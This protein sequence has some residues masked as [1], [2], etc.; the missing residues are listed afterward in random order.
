MDLGELKVLLF[1]D[2]RLKLKHYLSVLRFCGF[3]EILVAGDVAAAREI[4]LAT[5]LD[6]V[7]VTHF[8]DGAGLDALLLELRGID[9]SSGI[10]VIALAP[11]QGVP[12]SLSILSKGA[13][14]VLVEPVSRETLE[15]L[16]RK[17]LVTGSAQDAL[18]GML[19]QA[20]ALLE[21]GELEPA[22]GAFNSYFIA[23]RTV[24]TS[25]DA[26]YF[27]GSLGLARTYTLCK[28]W[29]EAEDQLQTAITIARNFPDKLE[30]HLELPKAYFEYG[31]LNERRGFVDKAIKSHRT[32]LSVNPFFLPSIR[33]LLILLHQRERLEEMI[34]ILEEMGEGFL[35][36]SEPMAEIAR[37]LANLATKSIE[38]GR[39]GMAMA[40]FDRLFQLPHGNV[41][42]QISTS[43]FFLA[44]GKTSAVLTHLLDVSETVK[45]Q[46]IL[47]KIGQI[48]LDSERW[49]RNHG[50]PRRTDRVDNSYF[51][52]MEPDDVMAMAREA[53]SEGLLIEPGDP[54][55][56]L[57][58][59]Y[60]ELRR[61]DHEASLRTLSELREVQK[62]D[63]DFMRYAIGL[64]LE[65]RL[66]DEAERWLKTALHQNPKDVE[67]WQLYANL[68][69]ARRRAGE[70]AE[71]L[72]RGLSIRPDHPGMN[73][74]LAKHYQ[75][76]QQVDAAIGLLER[77]ASLLPEDADIEKALNGL[78][79][80]RQ[81]SIKK[82]KWFGLAR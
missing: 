31:Y 4:I 8:D 27:E 16:I 74:A 56:R 59:A 53:F 65:V 57:H 67:C 60:C 2:Q 68:F 51:A 50:R 77:A 69:K 28:K 7:I 9:G 41:A 19:Q 52:E 79:S 12:Y 35:P 63:T 61:G 18:K 38:E 30:T 20:Q 82:S 80:T 36:Y 17:V 10:P 64:L 24:Y 71:C 47:F 6:L 55:G 70:A 22:V 15:R 73:L 26:R 75:E 3:R 58:L 21:A 81:Q 44:Q 78:L 5:H 54:M 13:A 40:L 43:D 49:L 25:Q 33:S 66:P 42:V 62:K 32:A 34:Q 23:Y 29:L 11:D 1:D 45:H 14:G 37:V 39:L 46:E 48:L 76:A 72:K